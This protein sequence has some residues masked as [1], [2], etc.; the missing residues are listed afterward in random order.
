MHVEYTS[1][2]TPYVTK[3]VF[4]GV[5]T[6]SLEGVSPPDY[7]RRVTIQDFVLAPFAPYRVTTPDTFI[8]CVGQDCVAV[9]I[10]D[11][12]EY[13]MV[14][15]SNWSTKDVIPAY[16]PTWKGQFDPAHDWDVF[17]VDN[18]SI[19]QIEFSMEESTENFTPSTDCQLYGF[20]YLALQIC[21]KQGTASNNLVLG[22]PSFKVRRII[23]G[24]SICRDIDKV[25]CFTNL[26]W[27]STEP[28]T[29][30]LWR[31]R[32]TIAYS[33]K[34]GEILQSTPTAD[35]VPEVF[36][37]EG[38]FDLY[39]FTYGIA[40]LSESGGRTT[41][42]VTTIR[43]H[44]LEQ[45]TAWL[46]GDVGVKGAG[47]DE[48]HYWSSFAVRS[49]L[50]AALTDYTTQ[51]T[52][53]DLVMGSSAK[54]FYRLLIPNS[55]LYGFFFISLSI[56]IWSACCLWSV[57]SYII[58]P[59]SS[60]FPEIDFGSKCVEF[61]Q[62]E[63][64]SESKIKCIG[65]VLFPLSNATSKEITTDLSDVTVYAGSTRTID[66]EHPHVIMATERDGL[67]NLFVGEKYR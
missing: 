53:E 1:T 56:I 47:G 58:A 15:P 28:I 8:D 60:L 25:D 6:F 9:R 14:P 29:A 62:Y 59:N 11:N 61:E 36:D 40:N 2:F 10:H 5:T 65:S 13:T 12:I 50:V 17:T 16:S 54:Q 38:L 18:A 23:V 44:T 33:R 51:K 34:D 24:T 27:L 45:T 55:S 20:P 57:K 22:R 43:Y 39:N 46:Q 7:I 30:S 3:P 67:Q 21:L 26:S 66:M 64:S 37:I 41:A 52:P 35:P 19:I 49:L 31:Q 4:S 42:S 48:D 63:G 32:A